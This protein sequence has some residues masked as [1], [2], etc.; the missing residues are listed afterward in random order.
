MVFLTFLRLNDYPFCVYTAFYLSVHLSVNFWVL[1][2]LW[3]MLQWTWVCKYL[4]KILFSF[5]LDIDPEVELLDHMVILFLTFWGTSGLF[6]TV[7]ILFYIARGTEG[8]WYL[9]SMYFFSVFFT[10]AIIT[11]VKWCLIVARF[12]FLWCLVML[13]IFCWPFL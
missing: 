1:Q 4:F 11:G 13:S 6:F 8:L 12:T 5:I 2:L 10:V 7:A 9:T 3:T